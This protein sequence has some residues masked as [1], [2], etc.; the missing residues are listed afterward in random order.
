MSSGAG[1][2]CKCSDFRS[3]RSAEN[4]VDKG[5]IVEPRGLEPLTPCL[6]S[7]CATN[8]AMAPRQSFPSWEAQPLRTK[9]ASGVRPACVHRVCG[10]AGGTVHS[11]LSDG[12][13]YLARHVA[14]DRN[15]GLAMIFETTAVLRQMPQALASPVAS[16]APPRAPRQA[17][18]PS[19]FQ[20]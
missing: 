14:R 3:P 19:E 4:R 16:P 13:D 15:R 17:S 18:R 20:G 9:P 8:C 1:G 11:L 5:K 2:C 10:Q 6:Q 12:T 7:K